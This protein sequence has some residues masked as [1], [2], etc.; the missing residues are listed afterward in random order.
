MSINVA[1]KRNKS[2]L[3]DSLLPQAKM[4]FIASVY[5][6]KHPDPSGPQEEVYSWFLE[7]LEK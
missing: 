4:H 5:N 6:M 1:D 7:F 2:L 3:W